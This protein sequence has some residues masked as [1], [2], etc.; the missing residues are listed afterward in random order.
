MNAPYFLIKGIVK[1]TCK[2]STILKKAYPHYMLSVL[3]G[4]TIHNAAINTYSR[5]VPHALR[6]Y[7]FHDHSSTIASKVS[8]LEDGVYQNLG[9]GVDS[10][11]VDYIR[12]GL[13]DVNSMNLLPAD[14]KEDVHDLE[15]ILDEWAQQAVQDSKIKVCLWGRQF[16]DSSGVL[17]IHDIH[18][19]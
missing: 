8:H 2:R 15:A 17:G 7:V 13:F 18:I 1:D 3:A 9:Q 10:L 19:L 12:S 5:E 11:A 16:E 14:P 4:N 6:Y